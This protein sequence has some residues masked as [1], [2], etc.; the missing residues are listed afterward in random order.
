MA[1]YSAAGRSTGAGTTLLPTV[2]LYAVT[3]SGGAIRE[4]GV[5][6][7][8]VTAV[9]LRVARLTTAGTP[10]TGFTE[11]EY[12]E[13]SPAPVM[14]AFDTHTSTGPTIA[15]G[16]F[17]QASLGAAIGSGLIWTF[18]G[19]GLVIPPGTANG[20]GII[21]AVGTGQI[22]DFYFDWEE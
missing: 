1:I 21:V 8:T 12:D 5:F 9:A 19:R 16:S 10:G 11:V 13:D 22:I 7:T 18:G 17:R 6:N 15:T 3:A 2:S 4:I 14:T 20:I